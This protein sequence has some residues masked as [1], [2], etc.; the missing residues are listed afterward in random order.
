MIPNFKMTNLHDYKDLIKTEKIENILKNI[1]DG[2]TKLEQAYYVY[3]ELGKI[4]KEDPKFV[5]ST[6]EEKKERYNDAI[7][8]QLF[9]ICKSISELYVSLLKELGIDA[10]LIK[11]IPEEKALSHVDTVL[12][13]DGKKYI[14]NLISDLANIKSKRRINSFGIN[15]EEVLKNRTNH[16]MEHFK[17][18]GI[19]DNNI[20]EMLRKAQQ[21]NNYEGIHALI[22]SIFPREN[23]DG[24][25]LHET[26][27]RLKTI[28]NYIHNIKETYGEITPLSK[29]E[30][31]KMDMKLGYSYGSI[32]FESDAEPRGIYINDVFH[33]LAE[34]MKDPET[35][36][37]YV[38]GGID[39]PEKEQLEYKLKYIFNIMDKCIPKNGETSYL[40]ETMNINRLSENLLTASELE[41]ITLFA[42]KTTQDVRDLTSILQ[43]KPMNKDGEN[44]YYIYSKEERKYAP[45]E[46]SAL[47]ET[48]SNLDPAQFKI[49]GKGRELIGRLYKLRPE[50][51]LEIFEKSTQSLGEET[52]PE[53]KISENK[54]KV[55]S[56]MNRQ[57][58]Q[59]DEKEKRTGE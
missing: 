56:T 28:S 52:F 4:V 9:G 55:V 22:D 10:D 20:E 26:I 53:Q 43:V 36:N 15:I 59:L 44:M 5:F 11:N 34:E 37:K 51:I 13:I 42:V 39:V 40:D 50:D 27:N 25:K 31:E 18:L 2:L 17:Q 1:P 54:D 14:V 23:K 35:V 57:Q 8:E 58:K 3:I 24:P 29:K 48:L 21:E 19:T 30:K 6:I 49:V 38:Y 46:I 32:V 41:R 47:K 12:K 16:V 7:D 45:I 33:I